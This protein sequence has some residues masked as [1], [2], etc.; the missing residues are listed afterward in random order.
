MKLSLYPESSTIHLNA[1]GRRRYRVPAS[2]LKSGILAS[3]Q[4]LLQRAVIYNALIGRRTV[5]V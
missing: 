4:S 3:D 5:Q 2:E 1:I